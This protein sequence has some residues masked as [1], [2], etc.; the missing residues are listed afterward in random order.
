M[1]FPCVLFLARRSRAFRS[2]SVISGNPSAE[3][4]LKGSKSDGHKSIAPGCR[5]K[6][7]SRAKSHKAKA[8]DGDDAHGKSP[9]GND[10]GAIE[11]QP[12]TGQNGNRASVV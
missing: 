6:Q 5:R 8:H 3:E 11:Q 7:R 12:K 10:R 1:I 2:S 4:N 9:A